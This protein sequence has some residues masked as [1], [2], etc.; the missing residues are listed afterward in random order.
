MKII[1][2]YEYFAIFKVCLYYLKNCVKN[3]VNYVFKKQ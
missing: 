3:T 1:R 2:Q